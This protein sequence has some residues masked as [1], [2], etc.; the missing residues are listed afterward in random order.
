M[1]NGLF[2]SA[3][4]AHTQ[5]V[6][7]GV[8]SNNLANVTTTGFKRDLA[9]F[10]AHEPFDL[11]HGDPRNTPENLREAWGGVT[12]AEVETD[13]SQNSIKPTEGNL[14]IALTG[15][16]FLRVSQGGKKFLTRDGR[17]TLQNDGTLTTLN[18]AKVLT[19]DGSPINIDVEG[20]PISI[21]GDGT[22][23][24]QTEEGLNPI[25]QLGLVQPKSYDKLRK[26]GS[27]L[28]ENLGGQT[29]AGP[30]LSVKQGHIETSGVEPMH[31][32]VQLIE[33]SRAFDANLNMIK[34]QDEALGTLLSTVPRL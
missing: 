4:G 3:Q 25:G 34:F 12:V 15:P 13:F 23:S 10:Q 31:E 1:I 30:E 33:T 24:Q 20:G 29:A 9:V 19:Q 7:L 6:R 28:Y 2:L 8:V 16:G 32:M 14:D 5:Q 11:V 26:V 17:F 22:I 18:G 27:N 21:A